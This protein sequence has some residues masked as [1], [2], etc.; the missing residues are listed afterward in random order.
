MIQQ[1]DAVLPSLSNE[2]WYKTHDDYIPHMAAPYPA[3]FLEV[4]K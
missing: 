3:Q 1:C 4:K 2:F